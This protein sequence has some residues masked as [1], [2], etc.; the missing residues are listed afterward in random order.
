M[1]NAR[2]AGERMRSSPTCDDLLLPNKFDQQ[3][4]LSDAYDAR[5]RTAI[6]HND[7]TRARVP[8]EVTENLT[9]I[10]SHKECVWVQAHSR[11]PE[12]YCSTFACT[13]DDAPATMCCNEK[14]GVA[15]TTWMAKSG[16][17]KLSA[18]HIKHISHAL[19]PVCR[20]ANSL[21]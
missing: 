1:E 19:R 8:T 13:R 5:S 3:L 4:P 18:Q 11:T 9:N 14:N 6:E 20:G 12:Y 15:S 21:Q 10:K 16:R 17:E 7:S 2:T